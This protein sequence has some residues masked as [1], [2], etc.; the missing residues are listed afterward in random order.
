[1]C[2]NLF[3]SHTNIVDNFAS[4]FIKEKERKGE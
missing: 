4:F 2:K 1:M 3:L